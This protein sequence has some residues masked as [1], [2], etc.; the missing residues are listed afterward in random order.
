MSNVAG[1]RWGWILV[2]GIVA[3][4]A[5]MLFVPIQ[6]LP[7]GETALLYLVVP[8]C[9]I[10]TGLAGYWIASKADRLRVLHGGLVGAVA[11]LIYVAL[12]W[13]AEL[14]AIYLVANY[15][16]LAGG[17]MGGWAADRRSRS[18]SAGAGEAEPT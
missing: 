10:V 3:E 15:L 18:M 4:I 2:G 6:L 11:L 13:T 1:L 17:L 14:P 12:T 8:L 9:V 7:G 5:L 16:K